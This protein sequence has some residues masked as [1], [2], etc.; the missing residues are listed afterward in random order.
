MIGFMVDGLDGPL[1]QWSIGS[2][3]I[4]LATIILFMTVL[5]L[6]V[7]TALFGIISFIWMFMILLVMNSFLLLFLS[8]VHSFPQQSCRL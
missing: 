4:R 7:Y 1:A 3:V 2:M 8:R 6:N 5:T